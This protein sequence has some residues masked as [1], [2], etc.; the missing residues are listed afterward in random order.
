MADVVGVGY[1]GQADHEYDMDRQYELRGKI[2][3]EKLKGSMCT[4]MHTL[5]VVPGMSGMPITVLNSPPS[6]FQAI[7]MYTVNSRH[8]AADV[9][10]LLPMYIQ[11]VFKRN[12]T[13]ND[14]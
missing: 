3:K 8:Y 13:K 5:P 4:L 11:H 12:L 14:S 6:T 2:S 1:P 10:C 7:H 9:A